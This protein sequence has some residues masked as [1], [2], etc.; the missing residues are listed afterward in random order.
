M[1]LC[2]N[3]ENKNKQIK[4]LQATIAFE[5]VRRRFVER[6]IEALH[7]ELLRITLILEKI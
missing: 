1:M 2:K 7:H 6:K 5:Q 4:K 3:C